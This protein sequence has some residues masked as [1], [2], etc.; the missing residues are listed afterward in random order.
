MGIAS[1]GYSQQQ[2]VTD[3]YI[4]EGLAINPAFAG[5]PIQ[6]SA[7]IIHR[8][9]WAN[10]PGSPVT[11]L[12]AAHSSFMDNKIGVG[13]LVS[14]DKIGIHEDFG[15]YGVYSYKIQMKSVNLSFGIQGGFNNI[16]SDFTKLKLKDQNDLLLQGKVSTINPN[17]GTG[18][19]LYNAESYIGFSVPYILNSDIVDVEGVLSEAKRYRYYYIYGGTSIDL[20]P[21]VRF[22]PAAFVRLQQGAPLSFDLNGM[23]IFYE[24]VAAGASYR[25]DDS[26][27]MIFELKL[28]ENIHLGYAYNYTISEINRYANGTHEIMLNYR[29][30]IPMLHDRGQGC[31]SYF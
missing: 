21:D 1:T 11:Q 8:D 5:A 3:L 18:A 7:T 27:T 16:S 19:L 30:R 13:L 20:S 14:S 4:F 22:K 9:Q 25:W 15:L 10:F 29:Y 31:P 12:F 17:F 6:L 26:I 24:T 2:P 28:H 23:F